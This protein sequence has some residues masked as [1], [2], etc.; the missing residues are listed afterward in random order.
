MTKAY[1]VGAKVSWSWGQGRASGKVADVFQKRV[2]R[3]IKGAKIVRRAT[4]DNPAYLVEQEDGG[5]ALKSHSELEK[6]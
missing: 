2:Q 3:T 5:K 6:D 4:A 1:G